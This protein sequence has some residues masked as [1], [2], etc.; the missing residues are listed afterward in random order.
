[1]KKS[2]IGRVITLMTLVGVL[3]SCS[4]E[5]AESLI[6]NPNNN[7]ESATDLSSLKATLV[8]FNSV[9][10]AD[11]FPAPKKETIHTRSTIIEESENN[12]QLVWAETDTIGIFPS[13]G[14]QVAFPMAS[15]AGT[16]NATFDGGGWGLKTSATYSAYYPLIGQFYLDRTNIPMIISTQV[17]KG[18]GSNTHIGKYDYM[19]A[20]NSVVN[21]QGGVE[22]NF[23]HLVS[24]LHMQIKMPKGG[25]YSYVAVETS[26]KFTTEATINLADG[27]VTP[28]KQSPIQIMRLEN[29]ELDNNETNPILEI[30][31]VI[32]PVDL[33]DKML[34]TKVYDVDNNCYTTTM[35]AMNFEGGT[36]YN[37]RKIATEDLTHTGLPVT[38]INTP[39][40]VD[41]TSKEDYV[42]EALMT[43]L[44][45]D[46]TD[47]FCELM[48]MK[49]RGNS[50]WSAAKKPYAIKFNKKKS[51]LSLPD[52]KSWVLLANYF[53]PTLLRNDLAF[54]MGNE[55]S[56]LDWTP[57][58]KHVD[59]MLNGQY[60]GI[61]Q[62]GEKVKISKGRVNVGDDGFLMEIDQRALS[63]EDARYFTVSHIGNPVNIKDPE[64]EYNDD[65]YNYAKNYV[66]AADA[67]LFSENFTDVNEGWQHYLDMDSFVDWY[68]I[69]EISKNADACTFFSSCYMHLKRGSKL[70]MG[71]LWD[72]DLGFGGYPNAPTSVWANDTEGFKLKEVP[73]Y[74]RLFEDPAFV[75]RVK[76]RFSYYYDNRQTLFNH[77]DEGAQVLIDK[78]VVENKLWGKI[79]N[80]NASSD[81]VKVAYQEKVDYLKTWLA[82]RLEWLN[83]NINAL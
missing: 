83:T 12:Y 52:D 59:L 45:T 55:L 72:F 8:D 51:L 33:T 70:K 26:G 27:T 44:Q 76:E 49:G 5:I 68:L 29:V 13:T 80:S 7:T 67:A 73:W 81:E 42:E 23:N 65:D 62:L 37:S 74:A 22:F 53:D 4:Q 35:Q 47:A 39:G 6:D 3:A 41:I 10:M 54:Y 50:T 20:V 56:I 40:N 48:N 66:Q 79:A 60:K 36:I 1:M 82:S 61:Y 63:E 9:T 38:I 19:A 11:E 16:K 31:L 69:N 46:I 25:Q 75:V 17:Q 15:S 32:H 43:I 18:N 34:Y 58:Y 64:V 2:I 30:W 57:H 71:P 24:V 28:T 14:M 77:I 21:E 78:V